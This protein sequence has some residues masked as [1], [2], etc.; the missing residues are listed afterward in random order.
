MLV[1]PRVEEV[2]REQTDVWQRQE[3]GFGALASLVLEGRRT[4]HGSNHVFDR[5]R[6]YGLLV[7]H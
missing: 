5:G 2:R 4:P 6:R 1:V 7:S 3:A